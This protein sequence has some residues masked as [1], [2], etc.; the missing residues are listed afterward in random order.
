MK[1]ESLYPREDQIAELTRGVALPLPPLHELHLNSIAELLEGAWSDLQMTQPQALMTGTEPEL[2]ALME[3]RLNE[4]IE[5][6]T[7]WSNLAFTVARGKET[8][9]FDG[10]HLE[11]RPDLSINLVDRKRNFPL[12]VECKLIDLS[13]DK[14]ASLYC[15]D[16]VIRFVVGDYAWANREAFMLAY[17]RD[18]SSV[19]GALTPV[20]VKNQ[21]SNP[22]P[23]R[24]EVVPESADH[25]TLDL[26][27]S[28]HGRI[29]DY[30]D[31][32]KP[33]PISL[34]HLWVSAGH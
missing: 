16:G 33:G 17:V 2:T 24:T 22:D 21:K 27:R 6:S 29:F 15:K 30:S 10:K 7:Y 32:N 31:G 8:N 4:L 23:Y 20:L 14:S 3:T 25:P 18:G 9:S 19:S 11:K 5:G 28:R 34:W 26:A 13:S 12:V 1:G